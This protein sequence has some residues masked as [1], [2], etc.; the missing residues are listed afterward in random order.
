MI[1]VKTEE[2][3]NLT[4]EA[5]RDE[6]EGAHK[7]LFNLR[8]QKATQQLGDTSTLRKIRRKIARIKTVVRERELVEVSG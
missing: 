3:R 1:N 6:L 8:F 5:L 4:T 2:I 7:E